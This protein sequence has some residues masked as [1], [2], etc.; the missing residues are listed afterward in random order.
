MPSNR[1][2]WNGESEDVEDVEDVALLMGDLLVVMG[3]VVDR[4]FVDSVI[5]QRTSNKLL[6]N[7]VYLGQ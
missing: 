7:D 6:V 5:S 1:L 4:V 3:R 2:A